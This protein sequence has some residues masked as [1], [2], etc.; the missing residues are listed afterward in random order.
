MNYKVLNEEF[1]TKAEIKEILSQR[2]DLELEQKLSKEH[3][4][5]FKKLKLDKVLKLKEDL[6]ALGNPKLN[7]ELIVKVIDI[8]PSN[9]DELKVVLQMSL[10]P[11]SDDEIQKV[12]ECL[13][14]YL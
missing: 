5:A 9:I 6:K 7:D 4:G 14:S 3:A 12:F 11:F 13:E 10:I 2:K 8:F 1:V